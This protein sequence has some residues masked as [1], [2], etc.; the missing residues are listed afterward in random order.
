MIVFGPSVP[1]TLGTRKRAFT[2]ATVL[3]ELTGLPLEK[4]IELSREPAAFP[5]PTPTRHDDQR[6]R[7]LASRR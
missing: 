7:R 2:R 5:L 4:I 3:D 1:Q 6:H